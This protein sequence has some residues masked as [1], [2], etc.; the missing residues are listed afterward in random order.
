MNRRGFFGRATGLIGA[1]AVVSQIKEL[2]KVEASPLPIEQPKVPIYTA[3]SPDLP[4]GETY[5]YLTC[6]SASAP[7][8]WGGTAYSRL[9]IIDGKVV[10]AQ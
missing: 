3:A 4:V 2:P 6:S 10:D 8:V 7:M 9:T 1:A 5:A